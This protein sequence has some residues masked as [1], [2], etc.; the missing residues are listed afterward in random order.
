PKS[1]M[2]DD[3]FM[4]STQQLAQLQ[5]IGRRG[6]FLIIVKIDV[7]VATLLFPGAG[8]FGPIGQR[9]DV[10][11]SAVAPTGSVA[12]D[13]DEVSRALPMGNE[14][15]RLPGEHEI[16]AGL[17]APASDR[18]RR[19]RSIEDA[20]QLGGCKLASVILKLVLERQTPWKKRSAPGIVVPARRSDQNTRHRFMVSARIHLLIEPAGAR[21]AGGAQISDFGGLVPCR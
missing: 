3:R 21:L 4:S 16:L 19:R 15:R 6:A 18:L 7:D 17:V 8:S 10:I 2:A 13:V 9:V 11:M 20:V 1:E 12:S 14:F 5:C